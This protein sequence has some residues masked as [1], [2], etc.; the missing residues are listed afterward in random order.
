MAKVLRFKDVNSDV[1]RRMK[2]FEK[3]RT[4]LKL[5]MKKSATNEIP[6][7]NNKGILKSISTFFSDSSPVAGKIDERKY[8]SIQKKLNN[9]NYKRINAP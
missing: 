6:L 8:N 4:K 2:E 1:D 5:E 3:M 9:I 7:K